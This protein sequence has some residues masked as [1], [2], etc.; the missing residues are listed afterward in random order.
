MTPSNDVRRAIDVGILV[1]DLSRS[2]AF[3]RDLLGLPVVGETV[4]SLIGPGRMVQLRYGEALIKLVQIEASTTVSS[5]EALTHA[6][7]FRYLTIPVADIEAMM[8]KVE[9]AG[10]AVSIPLTQLGNGTLIAM[11]ADRTVIPWSLSK[12]RMASTR[13]S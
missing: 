5:P 6:L 8:Q 3:Y 1:V 13:V 9:A 2:L 7:G 10:V 4:T 11:V 12:S